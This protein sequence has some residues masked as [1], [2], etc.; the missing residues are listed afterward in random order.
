MINSLLQIVPTSLSKYEKGCNSLVLYTLHNWSCLSL[1][2][3]QQLHVERAKPSTPYLS[4]ISEHLKVNKINSL[5]F[6]HVSIDVLCK[7]ANYIIYESDMLAA[8]EASMALYRLTGLLFNN[9]GDIYYLKKK[10]NSSPIEVYIRK[11]Y[12]VC[13]EYSKIFSIKI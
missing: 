10:K 7:F 1:T 12:K 3:T 9:N 6:T 11:K 8:N 4:L 5:N 13:R 2:C